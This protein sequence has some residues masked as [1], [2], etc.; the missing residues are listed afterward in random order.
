MLALVEITNAPWC[1][2][3]PRKPLN[4]RFIEV[5]AA[6]SGILGPKDSARISP[7]KHGEEHLVNIPNCFPGDADVIYDDAARF[8]ALSPDERV[9]MLGSCFQD[10]RSLRMLSGRAEQMDRFAEEEEQLEWQAILDFAA[11]HHE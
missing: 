7:G 4:A 9:R 2:K 11:R 1:F 8:R 3:Q 5:A 10:Y 6:H